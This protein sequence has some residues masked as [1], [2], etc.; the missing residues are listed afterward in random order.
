MQQRQHPR[1]REL[2]VESVLGARGI[3]EHAVDA[4]AVLLVHVALL[5]RLQVFAFLER[6]RLGRDDV[7][8]DGLELVDEVARIH[9]Q[10]LLDR[11]VRQRLDTQLFR[12]VVPQKGPAGQHGL[13]VDHHPAT[14]ADRHAAGPPET[15]AA[16]EMILDVLQALQHRH[17]VAKWHV[18]ALPE[19]LVILLRAVA[20]DFDFDAFFVIRHPT[21]PRVPSRPSHRPLH[22]PGYQ[23]E[24]S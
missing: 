8:R 2:R 3:A 20:Q 17:V 16:V 7:G 11:E 22:M 10:I 23:G 24:T 6:A 13:A 15:D 14:A 21:A 9:H 18:E 1:T 19:R 5:R 4:G 12:V